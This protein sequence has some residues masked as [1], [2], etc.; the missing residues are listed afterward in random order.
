M[1]I[2]CLKDE[3]GIPAYSGY[4]FCPG[5]HAEENTVVNAARH[6][7]SVLEGTL[8]LSGQNYRDGSS[9]EARPCDRCKRILINAGIKKVV[10]RK[11]DGGMTHIDVVDWIKEDTEK[12]VKEIRLKHK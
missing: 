7:A 4:E 10:L 9:A 1:E 12:Y 11:R 2:G 5:V 6:G 8:Y 3:L